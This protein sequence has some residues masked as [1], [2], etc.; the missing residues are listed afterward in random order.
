MSAH[1]SYGVLI[2][3]APSLDGGKELEG[4]ARLF[5]LLFSYAPN[6]RRESEINGT[7]KLR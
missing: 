7:T 2:V 1:D 3:C 6:L 4:F 5:E